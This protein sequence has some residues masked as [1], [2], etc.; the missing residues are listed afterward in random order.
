MHITNNF[1]SRLKISDISNAAKEWRHYDDNI[2]GFGVRIT[3]GGVKAYFVEKR[4][5]RKSHR[6]TLGR[7]P[8]LSVDAARHKANEFLSK[9]ANGINPIIEKEESAVQSSRNIT[10]QI[11]FNDY[12]H[13]RKNLKSSTISVYTRTMRLYFGDWKDKPLV[14]ITKELVAKRHAKIGESSKSCAN[15]SMQ[16]LRAIFTFASGQYDDS[17][18]RSFFADNPTKIIS[19]AR[20]WFDIKQR[21]SIIKQCELPRWYSAVQELSISNKGFIVRDCLLLILFTGL[22]K[23]EAAQ[24][25]WK[26]VSFSNRTL[27]IT[28]T[29]NKLQ[30]MLP[31]SDYIFDLL[32]AR[33]NN[34]STT[35]NSEYVFLGSGASG[36]LVEPRKQIAKV[37][38]TS[39]ISFTLH[40]LRRTFITIAESLD[41]SMYTLKKL[42]NH[43]SSSDITAGYIIVDVERLRKP[44]QMITDKLLELINRTSTKVNFID[45]VAVDFASMCKA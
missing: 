3:K 11:A 29:K 6:I 44:M 45:T 35:F 28:E 8:Y 31:L 9:I 27:T 24:L 26:N 34:A 21:T 36:H 2:K 25:K 16:L 32:Q 23:E 30:H 22:R 40:D 5:D 19:H 10:L 39:D 1:I 17:N 41:I 14:S 33:Y 12:I 7:Y 4:I 15:L 37:A 42:L 18:E 38:K 43:K 13:A 20:S